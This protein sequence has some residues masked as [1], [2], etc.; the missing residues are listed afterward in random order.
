VSALVAVVYALC[1]VVVVF[2]LLMLA[3]AYRFGRAK[4]GAP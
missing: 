1:A 2:E 3:L 4:A